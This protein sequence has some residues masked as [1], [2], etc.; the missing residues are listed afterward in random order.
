MGL[1]DKHRLPS[2]SLESA[3]T[4]ISRQPE[5]LHPL[6]TGHLL[7]AMSCAGEDVDFGVTCWVALGDT[8]NLKYPSFFHSKAPTL[9]SALPKQSFHYLLPALF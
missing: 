2:S 7:G 5:P 4:H 8:V 9:I 6:W 1:E 3:E